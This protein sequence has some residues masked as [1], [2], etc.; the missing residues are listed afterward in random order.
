MAKISA[1]QKKTWEAETLLSLEELIDNRMACY[2]A[3]YE[4]EQLAIETAKPEAERNEWL[5]ET[6][7]KTIA[8]MEHKKTFIDEIKKTLLKLI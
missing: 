1:I 2:D 4:R 7:E 3:T 8:E 5:I 6:H